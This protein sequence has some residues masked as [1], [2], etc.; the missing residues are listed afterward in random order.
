MTFKSVLVTLDSRDDFGDLDNVTWL[1]AS[2]HAK[3]LLPL[4]WVL[5]GG[6]RGLYETVT[7]VRGFDLAPGTVSLHQNALQGNLLNHF[8]V[9]RRF[10]ATSINANKKLSFV[11]DSVS[12]YY[13]V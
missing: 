7:G 1:G 6:E 11:Q 5:F 10:Q 2:L 12:V 13:Q 9:I 8:Q 4:F 3:T